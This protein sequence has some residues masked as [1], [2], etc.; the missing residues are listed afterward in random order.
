MHPA[1]PGAA[2]VP[3]AAAGTIALEG[4]IE[5]AGVEAQPMTPNESARASDLHRRALVV[6]GHSDILMAVTDNKVDLG[7]RVTLPGLDRQPPLGLGRSPLSKY[8]MG[9]HAIWF[10]CMGQ[11]DIPRWREGGV[12]AQLCAVYLEDK[13]L[14]DP[15]R[16]GMEMVWNL[17]DQLARHDE[18]V[19]ATTVRE[20]RQARSDGKIALV[21]T[22][23]GCE[24]LGD[25]PRF[26]DLYCRLG[27][28]CASLTHTRRNVYADGC[29]RST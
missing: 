24:P 4:V 20:I 22:F 23:E 14:R 1:E 13:W 25:D 27:L 12:G 3:G 6:D 2:G 28:R 17:H 18:I 19:L 21:L 7:E 15:F 26:L 16:R 10:G 8:G 9:P 5:L 29:P 11:Y